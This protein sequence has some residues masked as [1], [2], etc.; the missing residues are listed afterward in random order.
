MG[1]AALD[2]EV[3]IGA[4]LDLGQS[5]PVVFVAIFHVPPADA[6]KLVAAWYG[7]QAFLQMQPGFLSRELVRGRS[8][9]DVFIDYSKW[10]STAHFKAAFDHPEHQELFAAYMASARFIF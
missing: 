10:T 5:E 4:H 2:T 8:G 1:V 7:E 6:C 9:T 3:N